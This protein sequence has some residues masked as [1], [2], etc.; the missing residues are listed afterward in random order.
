MAVQ[1]MLSRDRLRLIEAAS[2]A[3]ARWARVMPGRSTSL[4]LRRHSKPLASRAFSAV[5][6]VARK[7][8]REIGPS[9]AAR[10]TSSAD[11]LRKRSR[12]DASA[13]PGTSSSA[14]SA[15]TASVI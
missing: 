11:C 10:S 15:S 8:S 3:S 7:A 2:M 9:G 1:N 6:L 13:S 5:T 12:R 4:R 14:S